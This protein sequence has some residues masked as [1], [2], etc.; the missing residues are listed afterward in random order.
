MLVKVR[1]GYGF[2]RG[3]SR[4]LPGEVFDI[5]EN[6]Y[7]MRH[8]IFEVVTKEAPPVEG[9]KV[10]DD[11]ANELTLENRAILDSTIGAPLIRKGSRRGR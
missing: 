8:Q 2:A 4:Y 1:T 11:K 6:E 9:N 10:A 7:R 5:P 3:N